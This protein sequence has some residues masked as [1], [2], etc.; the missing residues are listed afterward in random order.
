[1]Q[2]HARKGAIPF[3]FS[4]IFQFLY[5]DKPVSLLS[6]KTIFGKFSFDNLVKVIVTHLV[7]FSNRA[8]S[9]PP[10]IHSDKVERLGST[11]DENRDIIVPFL[12][13]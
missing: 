6:F 5:A 3:V 4:A 11:Y 1:M 9:L 13:L 12:P 10:S 8:L 2:R 7:V